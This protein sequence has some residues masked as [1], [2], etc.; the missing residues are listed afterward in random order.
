MTLFS[1]QPN[2]VISCLLLSRVITEPN[3]N[4][5]LSTEIKSYGGAYPIPLLTIYTQRTIDLDSGVLCS[6]IP[7]VQF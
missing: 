4:S 6:L 3:F 2:D 5:I 1:P 7:F